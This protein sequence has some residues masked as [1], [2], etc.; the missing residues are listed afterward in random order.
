MRGFGSYDDGFGY[1]YDEENIWA[2][3]CARSVHAWRLRLR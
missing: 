2:G 3:R 1:G